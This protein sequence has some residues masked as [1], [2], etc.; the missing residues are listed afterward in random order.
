MFGMSSRVS[1]GALIGV[2]G[3][4]TAGCGPGRTGTVTPR[5]FQHSVYKYSVEARTDGSL[6]S[7]E[8]KL[9]N[10]YYSARK[11]LV[12][13]DSTG[14]VVTVELDENGDGKYETRAEQHVYDLRFKHLVH[15]GRIFIRTFPV[16]QDLGKKKLS[17]LMQN[18]VEGVAGAGYEVV[19]LHPQ[20]EVV[21]EKRYAA[22]IEEQG[23]ATLAGLSAHVATLS[24]A[25]TEQLKVD[26]HAR[27]ERVQLVLL[28]TNFVYKSRTSSNRGRFPVLLLAGYAN[29]PQDFDAGLADFRELLQRVM[30]EGVRGFAYTPPPFTAPAVTPASTPATPEPPPPSPTAPTAL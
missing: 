3:V 8:W 18:Y 1:L 16:S 27:K 14:Y 21:I 7:T 22:A 20:E 12:E 13:K 10:Y 6:M 30:I 11:E 2:I 25:N 9:D 5:G 17:V 28:H 29:Q 15:D 26:P 24:V 23:P 19:R 4:V